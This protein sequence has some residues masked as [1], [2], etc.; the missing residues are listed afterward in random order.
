[1]AKSIVPQNHYVYQ[2]TF[3]EVPHIYFGSRTCKCLPE[4]DIKYM[5]SPKTYKH[6]W[7]DYTPIKTI[8]VSGFRTREEANTYEADLIEYQ[9]TINKPLSV[10][11]TIS[12]EKFNTVGRPKTQKQIESIRRICLG[13]KLSPEHIEAIRQ[14]NLGRIPTIEQRLAV[15]LAQSTPFYLVSPTGEIFRGVNLRQFCIKNELNQGNCNSVM[16]GSK[17]H[18]KG[19]TASIKAHELYLVFHADRGINW[20]NIY[21]Y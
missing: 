3:E 13:K 15:S 11:G 10:N 7:V 19:W 16:S 2:I 6:F 1:M 14:G 20:N 8:L 18:Y 5:G 21:K 9:W 17:F 12:N 4:D